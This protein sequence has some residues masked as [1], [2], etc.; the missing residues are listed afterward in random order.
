MVLH[1]VSSSYHEGHACPLARFGKDRD[2]QKGL[3]I[4][5]HG[6]LTDAQ[7]RRM[8]VDVYP[9]NTGG[10]TT[11]PDQVEKLRG[12]LGLIRVV[13]AGLT[14]TQIDTLRQYPGLGWISA[15]RSP[16]IEELV[17]GGCLQL[18]LLNQ[19][20]LGGITPRGI[21]RGV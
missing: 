10:P 18:S 7:G 14:E 17:R 3:P 8:T 4:I 16:A 5:V 12:R 13:L 6:V 11:V 9:G 15:L 21:P 19:R 1:D 20:N 2:G